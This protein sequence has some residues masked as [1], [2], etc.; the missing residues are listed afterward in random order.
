MSDQAAPATTEATGIMGGYT[1]LPGFATLPDDTR[2]PTLRWTFSYVDDGTGEVRQLP[3]VTLA[4]TE[5]EMA[6][7]AK[8]VAEQ[9]RQAN[10]A[11]RRG[12][13]PQVLR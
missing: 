6:R 9:V 5:H 2:L 12:F 10:R 1:V 7:L 11:A 13:I 3:P 8:V 4:L